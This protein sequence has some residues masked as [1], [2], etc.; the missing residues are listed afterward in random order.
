MSDSTRWDVINQIPDDMPIYGADYIEA[1]LT[2]GVWRDALGHPYVE[3]H[4][5]CKTC[6]PA[7]TCM[8]LAF[9][10]AAVV[11]TVRELDRR[12]L[13]KEKET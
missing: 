6:G 13:L 5:Y 9:F 2:F 8:L 12:G 10:E 4:G 3:G 7:I 11:S 1:P